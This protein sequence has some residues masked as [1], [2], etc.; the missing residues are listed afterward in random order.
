MPYNYGDVFINAIQ[1]PPPLATPIG[2]PVSDKLAS[3]LWKTF[4]TDRNMNAIASSSNVNNDG[5][6]F[7]VATFNDT[8]TPT[9][10]SIFDAIT[11]NQ[12]VFDRDGNIQAKKDIWNNPL[13]PFRSFAANLANG[14]PSTVGYTDW[15]GNPD[16]IVSSNGKWILAKDVA[17]TKNV[18]YVMY[19]PMNARFFKNWYNQQSDHAARMSNL[20]V[21]KYCEMTALKPTSL[22]SNYSVSNDKYGIATSTVPFQ[23]PG[24]ETPE[25]LLPMDGNRN[26]ADPI[27]YNTVFRECANRVTGSAID[28]TNSIYNQAAQYCTCINPKTKLQLKGYPKE[29]SF[30]NDFV[31][32]FQAVYDEGQC[33][34]K[35]EINFCQE[36]INSA[37]STVQKDSPM[38]MNCGT[39][40][41][42]VDCQYS[43][44]SDAGDCSVHCGGGWRKQT[45][46]VIRHAANGGQACDP[47][48]LTQSVQC[49]VQ[50]CGPDHVDPTLKPTLKPALNP[51]LN[52]TLK[53][54]S[55]PTLKPTL[56]PTL[57][58]TLAPTLAP[59]SAPTLK[60]TSTPA[61]STTTIVIASVVVL[62][63]GAAV[64]KWRS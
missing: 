62:G 9:G 56:T 61:L 49:N 20:N 60:P 47:N 12:F 43:N 24:S 36:A 16:M 46:S 30:V 40:G 11:S 54:T 35:I 58:P 34:S 4:H 51:T 59:T 3:K 38:M 7:V 42:G 37:G 10:N 45:R 19:N 63:V 23:M 32:D 2:S 15:K 14:E 44:W 33:P 8:T 57:T 25:S 39:Q 29:D 48:S 52:P 53:P 13:M 50:K 22:P 17:L 5:S 27:C 41:V 6:F 31:K 18:Y 21:Q 28:P 55:T 26:Y 64:W 1:N